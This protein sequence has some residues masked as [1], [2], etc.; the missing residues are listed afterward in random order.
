MDL[1]NEELHDLIKKSLALAEENN[2]ILRGMRRSARWGRF[3]SI[4]WWLIV[5]AVSGATYYYYV[6]PYVETIQQA[7]GNTQNFQQQLGQFFSQFGSQHPQ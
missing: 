3:F 4:A 6:Q 1:D 2:R 5:I 7:Y